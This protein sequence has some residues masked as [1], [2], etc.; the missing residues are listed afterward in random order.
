[1]GKAAKGAVRL[2]VLYA[3]GA[4]PD[5]SGDLDPAPAR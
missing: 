5:W 3:S 1:M 4:E 2:V